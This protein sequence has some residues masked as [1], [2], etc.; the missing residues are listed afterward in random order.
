MEEMLELLAKIPEVKHMKVDLDDT[1]AGARNL[2]IGLLKH[3]YGQFEGLVKL[4]T[5]EG[6]DKLDGL[7]EAIAGTDAILDITEVPDTMENDHGVRLSIVFVMLNYLIEHV[8][9]I[10]KAGVKLS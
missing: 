9:A 4:D 8:A 6:L 10:T 1:M 2:A 7:E 3:E 5:V